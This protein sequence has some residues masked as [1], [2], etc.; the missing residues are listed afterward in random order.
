LGCPLEEVFAAFDFETVAADSIGQA[1]AATLRTGAE[2]IVKVRLPGVVEQVEGDLAILE[3]LARTASR[4]WELAQHYDV[5]GLVREFGES[6]RAE[7]DYLQ[8]AKNAERFAG[9]FKESPYVHISRV[10]WQATTARVLTLE[11]IRGIKINDLAALDATGIDRSAVARRAASIILQ[12]VLENGFFHADPHPG[13]FFIEAGGRIGLI[14][15]GMVGVVDA[16]TQ[17]Q[18]GDIFLALANQ[19]IERLVDT[20]LLLGF[21]QQR[22]DRISFSRDLEHLLARYFDQPLGEIPLGPLLTQAFAIIRRHHLQLPP[23]LALLLKTLVM[24]ESLGCLLD[25][26]FKL[27]SLLVPFSRRLV[28]RRAAPRVWMQQIS[29]AGMDV[30]RLGVEL[31]RQLRRLLNELERGHLEVGLR[32]DSFEP[33]VQRFEQLTNRLVLAMLAAAFINGLAILLLV[34]RSV[35]GSQEVSL[36]F[37]V[38]FIMAAL[39]GILLAGSILRSR[40]W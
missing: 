17:E 33:L 15:F 27:T 29:Q 37:L 35:A 11:R 21:T 24:D 7:L 14:D 19:D 8:E 20:L 39:L 13:N 18:L 31:P 12:M 38:G 6:L 4:R 30:A 3:R 5:P 1:Y 9:T 2:V 36:L 32:P 10:Y 23:T 28:L 34:Y 25:P 16:R 40:R 22:L 26:T